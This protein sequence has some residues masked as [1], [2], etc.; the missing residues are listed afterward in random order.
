MHHFGSEKEA[1]D[2]AT[3]HNIKKNAQRATWPQYSKRH[4]YYYMVGVSVASSQL[5]LL[6]VVS[7]PDATGTSLLFRPEVLEFSIH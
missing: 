6:S 4:Y 2:S 5:A 3:G 1:E 7:G